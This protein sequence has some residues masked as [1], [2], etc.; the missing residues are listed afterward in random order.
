MTIITTIIGIAIVKNNTYGFLG[1]SNQI[2]EKYNEL[3][4]DIMSLFGT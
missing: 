1:A 2:V 3:E 4:S